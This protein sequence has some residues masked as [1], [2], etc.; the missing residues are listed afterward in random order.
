ML[1]VQNGKLGRRAKSADQ[2]IFGK[3]EEGLV[4][5]DAVHGVEVWK[6]F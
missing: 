5:N 4:G 1:S 2:E 6:S 3:S